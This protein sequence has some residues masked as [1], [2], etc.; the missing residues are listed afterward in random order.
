MATDIGIDPVAWS[1]DGG[2]HSGDLG[3]LLAYAATSGSEGIVSA[4]DFRVTQLATAGP[5]IRIAGGGLLIRNRSTGGQNQTYVANGRRT[6]TFD[7]PNLLSGSARSHMVVI[8]V[9]DPQYSPWEEPP[10]ADAPTYQYVKP[11]IVQNVPST[12]TT[13]KE[14]NLGYSA[15][16]LARIDLPANTSNIT[17]SHIKDVRVMAQPRRQREVRTW[18]PTTEDTR[19][20]TGERNLFPAMALLVPCPEWATQ[21]KMVV[22]IGQMVATDDV[23]ANMQAEYGWN[24]T[25]TQFLN[26]QASGVHHTGDGHDR[27]SVAIGGEVNIPADYRGKSHYVRI[28]TNINAL[29]GTLTV[30]WWTTVIVD[31]EFVEVPD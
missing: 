26:T 15:V 21:A 31:I 14:L 17:S 13:A 18:S 25:A 3:R 27:T 24:G 2:R 5:G 8:R 9:E 6:T 19:G 16:A 1:I 4:A 30:D 20:T 23:T 29:P 7:T 11:F 10:A 22:T 28:G 12:A